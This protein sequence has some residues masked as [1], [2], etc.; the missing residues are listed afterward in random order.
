MLFQQYGMRNQSPRGIAYT[1]K[2]GQ[3][4]KGKLYMGRVSN[5]D[6][7]PLTHETAHACKPTR[8]LKRVA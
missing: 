1:Y 8:L 6:S 3:I 5:S 4:K 7:I 2:G